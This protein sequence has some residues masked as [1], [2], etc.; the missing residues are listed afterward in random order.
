MLHWDQA[1]LR[2]RVSAL[3]LGHAALLRLRCLIPFEESLGQEYS[4]FGQAL[5]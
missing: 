3:W 2:V 4:L 1:R 5:R